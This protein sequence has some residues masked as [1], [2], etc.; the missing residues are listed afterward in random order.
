MR[1][2]QRLQKTCLLQRLVLV[3]DRAG[4][5]VPPGVLV[6][7]GPEALLNHVLCPL[8]ARVTREKV[9][10]PLED[11]P[12]QSLG[13]RQATQWTAGIGLVPQDGSLPLL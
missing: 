5:D 12:P 9:M 6:Q 8:D 3:A 2:W 10:S 13:N 1:H 7:H 4:V 11:I